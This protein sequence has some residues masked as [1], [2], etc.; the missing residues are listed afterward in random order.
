MFIVYGLFVDDEIFYVGKTTQSRLAKRLVEHQCRA[1]KKSKKYNR[2]IYNKIRKILSLGKSIEIR[3]LFSTN[4]EDEQTL[5]EIE[6][7]AFYGRDLR[8]GGKLYNSTDGG[9]GVCGYVYSE[10]TRKL[11]SEK[12]KG[13][14]HLCGIKRP[15][16]AERFSKT[17]SVYE[18]DGTLIATYNSQRSLA[19]DI[20]ASFKDVSSSLKRNGTV[21]SATLGRRVRAAIGSE[22]KINSD[23]AGKLNRIAQYDLTGALI[24]VYDSIHEAATA[25]GSSIQNIRSVCNGNS[26][27]AKSFIWKYHP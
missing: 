24:S 5:K 25:V 23:Y 26:K 11:M 2:K 4:S 12:K 18:L 17:T 10:E 21:F 27:T 20:G 14:K 16:M 1:L 15:D 6:L 8:K 22:P 19:T 7:I 3:V 9:E 13:S